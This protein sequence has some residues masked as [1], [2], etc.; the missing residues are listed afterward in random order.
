VAAAKHI[1]SGRVLAL[2]TSPA[3]LD[4]A[5]ANAEAHGVAGRIEFLQSDL[6]GGVS[7]G[8]RFDFIA[9]N[10]PYVSEAELAALAPGVR[11]F[12]PRAALLAGPRGTEVI[13]RLLPQAAQRLLPGG[14]LLIEIS[15]MIH[16]AA[17][18]LLRA[19]DRLEPGPTI[20]DFARLPRVIRAQRKA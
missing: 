2:D 9:S 11:D 1:P 5:R 15:P 4:V 19:E 17:L 12:E 14:S 20:K 16:D 8:R 6:L 18:A 7:D 13:D 10:P 3:A